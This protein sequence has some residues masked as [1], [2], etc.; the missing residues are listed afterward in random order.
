MAKGK[1]AT[2]FQIQSQHRYKTFSQNYSLINK[3]A[4]PRFLEH[5]LAIMIRLLCLYAFHNPCRLQYSLT[6]M[7]SDLILNSAS[8]ASPGLRS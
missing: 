5:G 6:I 4:K 2:T 1:A 3:K 7:L 8:G